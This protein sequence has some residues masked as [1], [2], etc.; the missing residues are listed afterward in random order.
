MEKNKF[1]NQ[2]EL[3]DKIIND[4]EL[5]TKNIYINNIKIKENLKSI[6]KSENKNSILDDMIFDK[7]SEL[8]ILKNLIILKEKKKLNFEDIISKYLNE[9][10]LI[11]NRTNKKIDSL[12]RNNI[13]INK[14]QK[15]V[16]RLLDNFNNEFNNYLNDENNENLRNKKDKINDKI[17]N[18]CNTFSNGINKNSCKEPSSSNYRNS[19]YKL[20]DD[21]NRNI[22]LNGII[23]KNE[24]NDIYT[25]DFENFINKKREGNKNNKENINTSINNN[26]NKDYDDYLNIKKDNNS[27]INSNQINIKSNQEFNKDNLNNRDF[28]A[29]KN[30]QKSRENLKYLIT[31]NDKE[32]F[33]KKQKYYYNNFIKLFFEKIKKYKQKLNKICFNKLKNYNASL[34]LKNLLNNYILNKRIIIISKI[35]EMLQ[36][37]SLIYNEVINEEIINEDEFLNEIDLKNN[38]ISNNNFNLKDFKNNLDKMKSIN[39]EINDIENKIR[40]FV[41]QI[42]DDI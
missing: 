18:L 32:K 37:S 29:N 36:K 24:L 9:L 3:F 8:N 11:N 39:K 41:N 23:L 40:N 19:K 12:K 21:K 14:K 2:L 15:I 28:K 13:I 26:I 33:I 1:K 4:M 16:N 30:L 25:K 6:K 38:N 42:N 34:K 5:K 22:D 20:I 17:Y 10:I 7:K 27:D 35:K 31:Q